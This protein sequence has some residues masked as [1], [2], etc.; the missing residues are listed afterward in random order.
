M[1]KPK[2]KLSDED[3]TKWQERIS[4]AAKAIERRRT[5][6]RE[7][8][9]SYSGLYGPE[10]SFNQAMAGDVCLP[11]K[12]MPRVKQKISQ[13]F[14]QVPKLQLKAKR[15][16]FRAAVY[17][18]GEVLNH[19][20]QNEL[21]VVNTVD[22]VLT[23]VLSISGI[24]VSKIGYEVVTEERE[25]PM[26]ADNQYDEE[27]T[28]A[29]IASGEIPTE[30]VPVPVF[31][32]YFW[33][34]IGPAKALIPTEFTGT[35][36][37]QAPWVGFRYRKALSV[38]K[39]EYGLDDDF[40]ASAVDE[41][42]VTDDVH[43][44]KKVAEEVECTEIWYKAYLFDKRVKHPLLQR[45]M[46]FIDGLDTPVV[47]E[48]SPYQRFNEDGTF[49]VGMKKFPIRFLTLTT[50]SDEAIPPSDTQIS[51]PLVRELQLSRT[52]MVQQRKRSI[53]LRWYNTDVIDEETANKIEAGE[54]QDMIPLHGSPANAI[55]EIARANYPRENFEFQRI[56]EMDLQEA[57]AMGSS[58]LGADSPGEVSATE[59]RTIQG[60]TNVRLDYE[61]NK[62]LRW[63]LDGAELLGS[64]IQMFADEPDY[65]E[66]VGPDGAKALQQWDKETVAGEFVYE[67]RPNSQLRLDVGQE[68]MD[69]RNLYQL[70]A[71]E[72]FVNRQ[73]LVE[74]VLETHGISPEQTMAPPPEK[75]PD[76]PNISYRFSGE[77]LNPMNPAFPIVTHI[78][79]VAGIQIPPDAIAQAKRVAMMALQ[80]QGLIPPQP[81]GAV[82]P[83][84]GAPPAEGA[85]PVPPE[86]EHGGP[87]EQVEPLSKNQM[88]TGDYRQ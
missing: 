16:E 22:E 39:R 38:A 87:A 20:L 51:A 79:T 47:H 66:V 50:V 82:P 54:V 41:K 15:P 31:E 84:G 85:G 70:M 26:V 78:L 4:A 44:D 17:I 71:N 52:Q 83:A 12:D 33:T 73:K 88:D 25:M 32:R 9:Q 8:A 14:Y 1:I 7:R 76:A 28:Q 24:G 81:A 35:D 23:D 59:V 5:R 6:W 60:N 49:A 42:V 57:W 65:V 43:G 67:A 37:D 19:K 80:M 48:N 29:L 30:K 53:P 68:R 36:F 55:G 64:I 63:F 18:F 56:I 46:V 34:R 3:A 2:I 13:L 72:P 86:V 10:E 74:S 69:S 75:Q 62:V 77:D 21:K 58:Q 45:R 61:R 40:S 27:T 11:N